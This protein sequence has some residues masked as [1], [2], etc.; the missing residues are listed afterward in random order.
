MSQD[1][2][3]DSSQTIPTPTAF[4]STLFLI[5]FFSVHRCKNKVSVSRHFHTAPQP[6]HRHPHQCSQTETG[7]LDLGGESLLGLLWQTQMY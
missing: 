3:R 7:T 6:Q 5:N 1:E 2:I 4:L